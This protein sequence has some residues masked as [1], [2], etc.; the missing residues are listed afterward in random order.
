MTW[1]Q[2]SRKRYF[3]SKTEEVNIIIEFWIFEL[4][5]V[6]I[7]TLNKQFRIFKSHIPKISIPAAKKKLT[8]PLNSAHSI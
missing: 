1:D 6:P 5:K 2:L 3:Q 4:V 8:S 7:F